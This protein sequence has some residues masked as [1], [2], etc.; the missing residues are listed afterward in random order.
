MITGLVTF[1]EEK[2]LFYLE[3][4]ELRL[5]EIEDRNEY[6]NIK[7]FN[8]NF[9]FHGIESPR[10][11]VGKDFKGRNVVFKVMPGIYREGFRTY[12]LKVHSYI[13]FNIFEISFDAIQFES[14]ELNWFYDVENAYSFEKEHQTGEIK[15][16]TKPFTDL[17]K[18]FDFKFNEELI[19]GKLN[20][21]RKVKG[22]VS[23]LNLNTELTLR[24]EKTTD[25]YDKLQKLIYLIKNV[26]SFLSYRKNISINNIFLKKIDP[27]SG[28]YTK[29]GRLYINEPVYVEQDPISIRGKIIDIPLVEGC[30]G[31]IF[32][33]ISEKEIYMRHIPDNSN[34]PTTPA[35]F[36]MV[37]AGF[38]W[39]YDLSGG[40][41]E[42][43]HKDIEAERELLLFLEEKI[44]TYTGRKKKYFRGI[45]SLVERR[46]NTLSDKIE[47]ALE[48]Y[49]DVLDVFIRHIYNISK[50]EAI[51]FEKIADRI[52][53]RRNLF[54]H[55][56]MTS[57]KD[58]LLNNLDLRVMEWLFYVLV[59]ESVGVSK[60]NIRFAIKK[61]FSV[62]VYLRPEKK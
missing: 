3:N 12:I 61:L 13:V 29:V 53:R 6:Y 7:D 19:N 35:H 9:F 34:I 10:Y 22:K 45:K 48:K 46:K 36:V 17:E 52:A 21:S 33:R 58:E 55:G 8:K 15:I 32:E 56:V 25:D 14:E 1:N 50:E 40:M 23:P 11:L 27:K 60:E 51:P 57:D 49:I 47:W 5:E 20:I 43:T 18:S 39:Q 24:F 28:L 54:A 37:T 59:L 62:N 41:D 44:E 38:E 26:F 2:C 4:F 31:K 30:L 42:S 16:E